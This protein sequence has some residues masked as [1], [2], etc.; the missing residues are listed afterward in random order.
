MPENLQKRNVRE[1][2]TINGQH[3]KGAASLYVTKQDRNLGGRSNCGEDA[4][5]LSEKNCSIYGDNL[6][7][8]KIK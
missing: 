2:K 4:G 6:L 1:D 3:P 5:R 8:G 7:R